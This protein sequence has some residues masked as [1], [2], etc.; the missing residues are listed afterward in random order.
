MRVAATIVY[1]AD[2]PAALG[3]YARA[4]GLEPGF[5]APDDSYA[6]LAGDGAVLAFAAQE[7]APAAEGA[8]DRPAGFE[9]WI[10]AEDVPAALAQ[11]LEAGAALE[12]EPVVKPWGQTVAYARAPDGVLVEIGSPVPG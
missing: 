3:F 9:V 8:R 7:M 12:Q 2:V 4:F 1:V 10:E 11:A 5:R 6:T